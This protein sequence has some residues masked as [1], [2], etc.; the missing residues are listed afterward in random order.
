MTTCPACNQTYTINKAA[1]DYICLHIFT[2]TLP[3]GS[4]GVA[5]LNHENKWICDCNAL[6]GREEECREECGLG[7]CI[8]TYKSK[9]L[10]R[11]H[12]KKDNTRW[13]GSKE[14]VSCSSY[15]VS[16]LLIIL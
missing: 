14:V 3:D 16:S 11:K 1:H 8:K 12:M 10:L 6:V 5:R 2:F 7:G 13:I 9:E 15:L 4:K